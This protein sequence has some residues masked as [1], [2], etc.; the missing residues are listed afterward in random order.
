MMFDST[1]TMTPKAAAGS[2]RRYAFTIACCFCS[3]CLWRVWF[4]FGFSAFEAARFCFK[5]LTVLTVLSLKEKVNL[6]QV[7]LQVTT[8]PFVYGSS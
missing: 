5:G 7:Q 1:E 2:Y 6:G 3:L 4:C 8:R